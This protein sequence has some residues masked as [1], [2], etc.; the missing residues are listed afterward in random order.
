MILGVAVSRLSLLPRYS[1]FAAA[2][3][4]ASSA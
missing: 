1:A 2:E 3:S 4:K